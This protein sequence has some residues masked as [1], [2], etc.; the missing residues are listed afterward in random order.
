MPTHTHTQI[1]VQH[2]ARKTR[3]CYCDLSETHTH[4]RTHTRTHTE[5]TRKQRWPQT[6]LL[7][8]YGGTT[9]MFWSSI[10]LRHSTVINSPAS[11]DFT[12]PS[13]KQT[14]LHQLLMCSIV[15]AIQSTATDHSCDQPGPQGLASILDHLVL[16]CTTYSM[17]TV[18][19][20]SN[21]GLCQY[22]NTDH[23]VQSLW[24]CRYSCGRIPFYPCTIFIYFWRQ[25]SF[26]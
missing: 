16:C 17:E 25:M 12:M 15:K 11:G 8:R 3:P 14:G 20:T 21:T 7:M 24:V 22:S 2:Q 5:Y 19:S 26:W 4:T 9:S 18:W 6:L 1:H 23:Y 10:S 13:N